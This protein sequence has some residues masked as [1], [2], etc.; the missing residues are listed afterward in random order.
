MI[1]RVEKHQS[2]WNTLPYKFEA[3]TP[4]VAEVVGLG[5]AVDFLSGLGM[6][7][8]HPHEGALITYAIA[9]LSEVPGLKIY[10]P[11]PANRGGVVPFTLEGI[12]PHDIA[13]ILDEDG[14][15]IRAGLHCAEPLHARFSLKAT[16]RASFYIYNDEEDVDALVHGLHKV[17]QILGEL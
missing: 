8:V 7:A 14:V 13:S 5:A 1:L 15:C 11:R 10:G 17:R 4:P 12:H 6:E 9:R 2:T 16:A 3:G